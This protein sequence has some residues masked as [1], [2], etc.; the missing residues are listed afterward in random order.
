MGS[1]RGRYG[2]LEQVKKKKKKMERGTNFVKTEQDMHTATTQ[3]AE[4]KKAIWPW[5][6]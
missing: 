4:A 1:P 5:Q 6:D 3:K 2:K